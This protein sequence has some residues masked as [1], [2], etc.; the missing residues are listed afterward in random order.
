MK[1][2]TKAVRDGA[3]FSTSK[4]VYEWKEHTQD[5]SV[6]CSLQLPLDS[7]TNIHMY[8]Y[9][10]GLWSLPDPQRSEG[11]CHHHYPR[12]PWSDSSTIIV[13]C[14]GSPSLPYNSSVHWPVLSDLL[15]CSGESLATGMWEHHML[16][17]LPELDSFMSNLPSASPCCYEHRLEITTVRP[18]PPVVIS[19]LSSLLII[20]SRGCGRLMRAHHY[21]KQLD[22]KCVE[23]YHLEV[24]SPS[25]PTLLDALAKPT[26]TPPHQQRRWQSI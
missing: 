20:C 14:S 5:C 1:R 21:T 11:W 7:Y 15:G 19:L 13:S 4:A 24:N 22:S 17:L 8:M 26:H 10:P 18:P 16:Q 3:C 2:S 9:L 23:Y 6:T 12:A 25:K